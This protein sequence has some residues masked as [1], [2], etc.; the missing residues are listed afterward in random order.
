MDDELPPPG[1][2]AD[3]VWIPALAFV[4][5]ILLAFGAY[6]AFEALRL[7]GHATTAPR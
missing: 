2:R 1:P 7:D 3:R 5:A 6:Q 4:T